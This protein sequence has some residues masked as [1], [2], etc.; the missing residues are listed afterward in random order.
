[1]SLSIVRPIKPTYTKTHLVISPPTTP[2][3]ATMAQICM[4]SQDVLLSISLLTRGGRWTSE[5]RCTSTASSS[6]TETAPVSLFAICM[7]VTFQKTEA[8]SNIE[9]IALHARHSHHNTNHLFCRRPIN[10]PITEGARR[11]TGWASI[12]YSNRAVHTTE[13]AA[14]NIYNLDSHANKQ[15][16]YYL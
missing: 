11:Y 13:C 3:M 12:A 9:Y 8:L 5:W 16:F 14:Q 1:M 2:M 15:C 4:P 7:R 6:P 10:P